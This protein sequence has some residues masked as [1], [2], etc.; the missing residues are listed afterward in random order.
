MSKAA[1]THARAEEEEGNAREI[2][3]LFNSLQNLTTF[4]SS[5]LITKNEIV[6]VLKLITVG[7]VKSLYWKSNNRQGGTKQGFLFQF[8]SGFVV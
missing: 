4:S 2:I 8:G 5:K 3:V 7:Y 6:R 1:A